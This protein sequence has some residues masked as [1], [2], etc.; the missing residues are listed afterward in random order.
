VHDFRTV[1]GKDAQELSELLVELRRTIASRLNRAGV[2][3][4]RG[5]HRYPSTIRNVIRQQA[6]YTAVIGAS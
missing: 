2:R 4:K 1:S 3:T 5:G 6:R